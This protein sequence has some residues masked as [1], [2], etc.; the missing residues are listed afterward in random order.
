MTLLEQREV[1]ARVLGPVYRAFAAELG[2]PRAREILSGV[3]ASLARD[4]GRAAAATAGGCGVPELRE[5]V[6]RWEEG[7]AL[8]ITVLEQSDDRLDFDVIHCG[9]AEMYAR[10]G[11]AD[12]GD[13][14][15]CSRDAAMVEGFNPDIKLIR[16]RT[17][18]GGAPHCPFR[19]RLRPS[20]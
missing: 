6:S 2:E 5:A 16:E 15:S 18:L 19:Y 10:L 11:L 8:S 14:L 13:I 4:A 3:V 20:E 9:F 7:G 1:E 17:I 12:I